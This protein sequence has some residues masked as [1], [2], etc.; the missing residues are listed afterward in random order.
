MNQPK[1]KKNTVI[2]L[3]EKKKILKNR[4]IEEFVDKLL[5]SNVNYLIDIRIRP[6]SFNKDYDGDRLGRTLETKKIKYLHL[7]ELGNMF[8]DNNDPLYGDNAYIEFLKVSGEFVTRRL[9][10][11][12]S[13]NQGKGN[14]CIL[15]ACKYHE[16]CH[17]NSVSGY[18]K[19]NFNAV[20]KH[21]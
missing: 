1:S 9:R 21:L 4:K 3:T 6:N 2:K 13:E 8:K 20:I 5:K 11:E 7:I 14:L 10:K 17:R 12:I 18:L 16:T 19:T 15:C